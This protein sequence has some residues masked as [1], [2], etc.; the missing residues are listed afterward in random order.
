MRDALE[1][2]YMALMAAIL[3]DYSPQKILTRMGLSEHEEYAGADKRKKRDEEIKRR[4]LSGQRGR[5][6]IRDM[7]VSSSTVYNLTAQL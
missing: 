2:N 4:F 5:D 1:L 6:I 7:G 3:T